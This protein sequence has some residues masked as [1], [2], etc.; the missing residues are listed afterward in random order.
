MNHSEVT[1][2]YPHFN[3]RSLTDPRIDDYD[4]EDLALVKLRAG[5]E[6]Q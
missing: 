2:P 5:G 4:P 6:A 3:S 1:D